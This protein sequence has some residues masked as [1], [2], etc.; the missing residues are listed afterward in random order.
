MLA[1]FVDLRAARAA[2]ARTA[3]PADETWLALRAVALGT[4]LDQRDALPATAS[5][6]RLAC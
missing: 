1:P 2:L 4:W 5:Q 3:D 6:P